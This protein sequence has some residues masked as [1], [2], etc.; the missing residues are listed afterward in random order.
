MARFPARYFYND[1][2][3]DGEGVTVMSRG[4]QYH[5]N[6]CFRPMVVF[7]CA[8][9][10]ETRSRRSRGS[11]ENQLE[12]DLVVTLLSGVIVTHVT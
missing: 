4:T 7:D 8:D 12:A 10:S 3:T 9:G 2:L 6:R 11:M 1:L 5:V